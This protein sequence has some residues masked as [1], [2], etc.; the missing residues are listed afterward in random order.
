MR[1][2]SDRPRCPRRQVPD[3]KFAVDNKTPEF[4]KKFP[5]GK[6]P[7]MDTPFGPL[8]ESMAMLKY[9]EC[10]AFFSLAFAMAVPMLSH[11]AFARSVPRVFRQSSACA[12]T[13]AST[14][15]TSTRR[16]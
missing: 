3:F 5:L 13:L 16:R 4:L 9:S 2:R 11:A 6:V 7:A 1:A 15:S 14:A 8:V 10:L 12:R